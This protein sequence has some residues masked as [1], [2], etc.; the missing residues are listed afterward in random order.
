ML[1]AVASTAVKSVHSVEIQPGFIDSA[2][3]GGGPNE[4]LA[5][6]AAIPDELLRAHP[7]DFLGE[8]GYRFW[9]VVRA[10]DP[11]LASEQREGLAWTRH[12]AAVSLMAVYQESRRDLLVTALELLRRV[13]HL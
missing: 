11:V 5:R 3:Y 13:G 4:T 7:D 1:A 10:G 2:G 8:P 9:V 6:F 12:H